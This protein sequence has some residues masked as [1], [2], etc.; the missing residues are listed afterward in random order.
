MVFDD[1]KNSCFSKAKS[2]LILF[3]FIYLFIYFF[4]LECQLFR[5]AGNIIQQMKSRLRRLSFRPTLHKEFS[6]MCHRYYI[7]LLMN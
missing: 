2:L 4:F 3:Y 1:T 5:S 7:Q 6:L